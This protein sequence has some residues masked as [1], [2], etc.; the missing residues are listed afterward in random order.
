MDFGK[1]KRMSLVCLLSVVSL[2]AGKT[3]ELERLKSRKATLRDDIKS[4][5]V[6]LNTND[7]LKKIELERFDLLKARYE[8]DLVNKTD[9]ISALSKRLKQINAEVSNESYKQATLKSGVAKIKSQREF[10]R[11]R[12]ANKCSDLEQELAFSLP[13]D[14]EKRVGRIAA[15][16]RDLETGNATIEEGFA[17]LKAMVN[18]EI[19]FGD[20]IALHN[21]PI[22]RNDGSLVNAEVL[23]IGNQWML[24]MDD[25]KKHYGI[26]VRKGKG[27]FT[28]KEDLN[29]SEREAVRTAIEVKGSKKPPQLV[30]LPLSILLQNE[31]VK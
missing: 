22:S 8:K 15:L 20:E 19:K 25:E 29:F 6:K 23:R 30:T 18:D 4:V 13:W 27:E 14:L 1:I 26:L 7:S 28:W 12:L 31:G 16:R 5:E 21:K 10:L 9:E 24:Y 3:E 11:Q 17:R 2:Y